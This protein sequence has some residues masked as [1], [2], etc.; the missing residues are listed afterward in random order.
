MTRKC[1]NG[2]SL[3]RSKSPSWLMSECDDRSRPANVINVE[4][5]THMLI[6]ITPPTAVQNEH[7]LACRLFDRGLQRLHIR[8][9]EWS[10]RSLVQFIDRLDD[11][12]DRIVLH[13][14]PSLASRLRV[15]VS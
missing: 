12:R 13:G 15:R 1:E 7:A 9:P 6:V 11:Y 5:R 4:L 10:E 2:R 14:S 8:K 3:Q